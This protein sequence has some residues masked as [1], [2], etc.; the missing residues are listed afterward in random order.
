MTPTRRQ[1]L[2]GMAALPLGACA[3]GQTPLNGTP[4]A[5]GGVPFQGESLNTLAMRKGRRF[6]SAVGASMGGGPARGTVEN[7]AY[8]AIL[9]AECGIVV[10]ENEMK[11]QWTRRG[12][13]DSFDFGAMDR[14]V[15]WAQSAGVAVR[16]HTLYWARDRWFP[17]WLLDHD[18]GA[19]PVREAERLMTEH[20][21][22]VTRRYKSTITSYDVVNEAI[23]HETNA[24]IE[25]S[26]SRAMGS[27]EAT[28]DLAFHTAREEL[29][30]AEL[31]YNDYMSWEPDHRKHCA[32]VLRLLEGF[33]KRNV[34][35]D[36]LGI[37]SHIEIYS[38]DPATR[39]GP[40]LERE[41]QRFIDEAVA[42]GYR[43]IITEFDVKDKALTSDIARR[44]AQVAE[45]SRR[46]FELMLDYP[47]MG[48]VLAWG[49]VDG[50]NWLQ[51]FAPRDDGLEVR[52]C[53]YG[54]DYRPKP[55]RDAL[56]AVLPLGTQQ[57][58]PQGAL[59]GV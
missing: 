29:P 32:D 15:A 7:P 44:D 12:G 21:R 35:V 31:V 13:P 4:A 24:P 3:T 56:A 36:T 6:G 47:Q 5:P 52:G 18:F 30:D 45:F 10:P 23:D 40:Y 8:T 1:A 43:L 11:W 19:N 59:P 17:Q 42:M 38:T 54:T 20:V 51:G 57:D 14:I 2:A 25:T 53:P 26:L 27:V 22:A 33:R 34:P 16:G 50:F 9:A 55:L 46:Y 37:Q 28:L 39:L 58:V 49:M 41:W 48:D